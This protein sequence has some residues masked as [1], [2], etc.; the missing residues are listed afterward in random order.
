[1]KV[2]ELLENITNE[3][4]NLEDTL[5]IKKYLPIELKKSIAEGI[6]FDCTEEVDGLLKIDS[7]QKY[8]S[9]IRHMIVH[10]TN[11]EYTDRDYDALCSIEYA[12]STL[13]NEIMNC[14]ASDAQE[15]ARI[16]D[17]MI[18]DL[19]HENSLEFNISR[20]VNRLSG[21]IDSLSNAFAEKLDSFD[22]E[23]SIAENTDLNN[24]INFLEKFGE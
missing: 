5:E 1:M 8:M 14:F 2:Q 24:V 3:N 9:Y 7:F 23:K 20:F 10:H 6:I 11:L 17:L 19:L 21:A 15:C 4:F 13:L 22:F 18:N 16:S 12:E